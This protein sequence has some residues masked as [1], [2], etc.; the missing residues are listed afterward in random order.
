MIKICPICES[1]FESK[2]KRQKYCS[3]K[4]KYKA[5][6]NKEKE[7]RLYSKKCKYCGKVFIG[8]KKTKYCSDDCSKKAKQ[9]YDANY[10]RY[11]YWHDT[12]YYQSKLENTI[13]TFNILTNLD[14]EGNRDWEKE[15]QIIKELKKKTGIK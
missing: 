7:N 1:E 10:H 15:A 12:E 9:D 13:G 3:K 11:R 5:K 14:D 2:D 4:C 8:N 6:V